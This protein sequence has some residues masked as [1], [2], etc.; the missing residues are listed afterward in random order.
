MK[1]WSFLSLSYLSLPTSLFSNRFPGDVVWVLAPWAVSALPTT[2]QTK[3]QIPVWFLS[4][5]SSCSPV[6]QLDF[7]CLFGDCILSGIVTELCASVQASQLPL[8]SHNP[9]KQRAPLRSQT[10]LFPYLLVILNLRFG[11]ICIS[12]PS[13]LHSKLC[14]WPG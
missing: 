6:N 13:P 7:G 14:N 4:S 2:W 5:F 3:E 8:Q 12:L 10:N 11:L 1:E 9:T